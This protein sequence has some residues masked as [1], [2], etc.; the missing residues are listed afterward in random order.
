M[1]CIGQLFGYLV[2][3]ELSTPVLAKIKDLLV[4]RAFGHLLEFEHLIPTLVQ[5][6]MGCD[7]LLNSKGSLLGR[8]DELFVGLFNSPSN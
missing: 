4:N 8:D 7:K 5:L 1:K 3:I 6:G 2:D